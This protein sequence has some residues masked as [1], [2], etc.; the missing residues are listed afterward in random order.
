M[1][2]LLSTKFSVRVNFWIVF[3]WLRNLYLILEPRLPSL[4]LQQLTSL[5]RRHLTVAG[6]SSFF[7]RLT[8][9]N[10]TDRSLRYQTVFE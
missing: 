5:V 10:L 6:D 1:V 8:D 3:Y 4:F 2:V 9:W 7:K